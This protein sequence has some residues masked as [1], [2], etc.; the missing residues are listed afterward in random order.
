MIAIAGQSQAAIIGVGAGPYAGN[1]GII[2]SWLNSQGHTAALI[3]PTVAANFIGLDV[4]LSIRDGIV[5]VPYYPVP[6]SIV[7]NVSAFVAAGGGLV[8]E[9]SSID[10]VMQMFGGTTVGNNF[11]GTGTTVDINAVVHPVTAGVS[12][13]A[14]SSQTEFNFENDVTGTTLTVLGTIAGQDTIMVG[15]YFAGRAV[16]ISF[17]WQDSPWNAV[18]GSGSADLNELLL[19][20]INWAGS[21]S[22]PEVPEPTSLALL[23]IGS[24]VAGAGALR[25]R[26]QAA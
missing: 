6:A 19:N 13:F 7:A 5:P 16:G 26:R 17:D 25:R 14:S 2:T 10:I 23:G 20:S 8:T 12:D 21:A 24:V 1:A 11:I 15:D 22:G 3:D 4:Y 18:T 9:W